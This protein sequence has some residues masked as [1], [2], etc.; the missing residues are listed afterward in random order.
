MK[1]F[2]CKARL[3]TG[4]YMTEAT[5]AIVNASVVSRKTVRIVL[6]TT[7]LNDLEVFR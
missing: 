7:T 1:D 4:N 6:L 3:K 2:R 5:A